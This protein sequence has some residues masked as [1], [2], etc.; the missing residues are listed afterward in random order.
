MDQN[1]FSQTSPIYLDI[2][3]VPDDTRRHLWDLPEEPAV[4]PLP[5]SL[6]QG[7]VADVGD[8]LGEYALAL[9]PAYLAAI[10]VAEEQR[11]RGP[12]KGVR[13]A[14][15]KAHKA[16]ADLNKTLSLD[17]ERCRIAALGYAV[18]DGEVQG[19]AVDEQMPEDELL[20]LVWNILKRG[21]KANSPIVGYNV[22]AF[23]LPV[24]MV[25]SILLGVTPTRSVDLRKYGNPDMV[26][27]M[28]A[29]FPSGRRKS[30]KTLAEQYDIEAPCPDKDGSDV[31]AMTPAER[32]EYVKSDVVVT[33]ALHRRF[34]GY[35]CER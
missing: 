30:L 34:R 18:G 35:F 10:E 12:R 17:P 16:E 1:R 4:Y 14:L 22:I 33:R 15:A 6:I 5:S 3:T 26:D 32:T 27:L 21:W 13:G 23:D 7:T 9:P 19:I 20:R 31:L 24:I 25:R 2:E 29:R 11:S 28:V 8:F